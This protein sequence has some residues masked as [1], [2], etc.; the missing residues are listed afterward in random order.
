MMIIHLW[1]YVFSSIHLYCITNRQ[2]FFSG[3]IAT[4]EETIWPI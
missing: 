2:V 4:T 3:H 1:C